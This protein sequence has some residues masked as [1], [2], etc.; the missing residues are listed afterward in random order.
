MIIKMKVYELGS[1]ISYATLNSSPSDVVKLPVILT[2]TFLSG[3]KS[4]FNVSP[5]LSPFISNF[6]ISWLDDSSALVGMVVN[7]DLSY[8][9]I[10]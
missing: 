3:L 10:L 2:I 6:S 5:L 9:D 4:C 7:A 8:K 1:T